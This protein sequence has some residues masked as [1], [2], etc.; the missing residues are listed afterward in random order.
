M[1]AVWLCSLNDAIGNIAVLLAAAGVVAT[2]AGWPDLVV[3]IGMGLLG[4]TA[5]RARID[6]MAGEKFVKHEN[7]IVYP[8]DLF[9]E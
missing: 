3:A 8:T 5:A 4:L 9:K 2:G 7:I 1:R 6:A